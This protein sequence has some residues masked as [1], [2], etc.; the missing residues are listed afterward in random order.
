MN[1]RQ[2]AKVLFV[3]DEPDLRDVFRL[4]A[5]LGGWQPIVTS[6]GEEAWELMAGD[7]GAV[8]AMVTDLKMPGM[9]GIELI[10]RV[11]SLR[12]NLPIAVVSGYRDDAL[13]AELHDFGHLTFLDKPFDA[14]EAI[15]RIGSL[16]HGPVR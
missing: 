16:L 2:R 15:E 7:P 3:E 13:T 5:E 14:E 8:D 9:G 4:V 11:R 1:S 6:S 10:R 12:E